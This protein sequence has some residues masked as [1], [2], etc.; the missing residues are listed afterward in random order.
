MGVN[1]RWVG[2]NNIA[3][4]YVLTSKPVFTTVLCMMA[5]VTRLTS[6]YDSYIRLLPQA[7][8]YTNHL[9]VSVHDFRSYKS[10]QR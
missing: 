10:S 7:R 6:S 2:F 8:H 3:F 5:Y 9:L 1:D 4:I